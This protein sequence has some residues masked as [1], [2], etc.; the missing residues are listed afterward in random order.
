MEA[1]RRN[2]RRLTAR[3]LIRIVHITPTDLARGTAMGSTRNPPLAGHGGHP[4]LRQV[5]SSGITV[6]HCTPRFLMGGSLP[7]GRLS[8][9]SPDSYKPFYEGKIPTRNPA[10]TNQEGST[11]EID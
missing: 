7:E 6:P 3:N 10:Q 8:L 9:F 11:H 2:G 4:L 5:S 1:S